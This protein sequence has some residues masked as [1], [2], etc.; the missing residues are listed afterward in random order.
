M[1]EAV[2]D[3]EQPAAVVARERRVGLVEVGDVGKGGGQAGLA[4]GA[5]AGAIACS[6]SPRP[7]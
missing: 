5:Q 6:I 2:A 7:G 1:P 4:G 3:R